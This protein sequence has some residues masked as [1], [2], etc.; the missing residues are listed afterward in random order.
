MT[1]PIEF[2]FEFS[3]PYGYF[4]STQVEK[5][6]AEFGRSVNWH[7]IL[8]GPMFKAMGSQPLTDIPLKG[9]YARRDFARTAALF[10]IPYD[11]PDPFPIATVSAA[12]AVLY[13]R[14]HDQQKSVELTKR[15]YAAYFSEQQN[16]SGTDVVLAIADSIGLNVQDLA[17]GI[18]QDSTKAMLRDEVDT[19]MQRGVFGSPFLIV[20]GEP[21]WG[22][23]RFDH[24]RRWLAR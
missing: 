14:Q 7:P 18:G 5:L 19:A 16:I 8:L 10:D 23:D 3:S 6:A 20:D 4:A 15:L 1:A 12:R 2:Y 24:I 22:F 11:H 13:V 21:F 9:D 17:E